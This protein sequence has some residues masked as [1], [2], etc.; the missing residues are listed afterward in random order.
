MFRSI[1]IVSAISASKS[2][3]DVFNT[4]GKFHEWLTVLYP[5]QYEDYHHIVKKRDL[6]TEVNW[7][8]VLLFI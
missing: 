4:D 2:L 1:C 3:K 7:V 8:N 5:Q 6:S